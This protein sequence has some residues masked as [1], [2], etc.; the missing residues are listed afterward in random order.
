MGLINRVLAQL[1]PLLIII[2]TVNVTHPQLGLLQWHVEL[3][4]GGKLKTEAALFGSIWRRFV[5]VIIKPPQR[6]RNTPHRSRLEIPVRGIGSLKAGRP[7]SNESHRDK[8]LL[9]IVHIVITPDHYLDRSRPLTFKKKGKQPM[10][11]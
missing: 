7:G 2:Q 9:H 3:K 10:T 1:L 8:K 11:Q 6:A 5:V 4:L